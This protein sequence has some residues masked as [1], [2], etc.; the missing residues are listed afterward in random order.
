MEE[1]MRIGII[2]SSHGIKGSMKII[3]TTDDI[4]RFSKLKKAY[5]I[6]RYGREDLT[7]EEV[8]YL[9]LAVVVRFSQINTPEDAAIYR[10]KD[11]LIDRSDAMPLQE[12]RYYISDMIGCTVISDEDIKLGIVDDVFNTAGANAVIDIK[13]KDGKSVLIPYT[14]ECVLDV[15]IINKIIKVHMLDGLL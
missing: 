3:P 13:M 5:V 11:L 8:K 9:N 4:K 15:D 10:G 12:G 7:V 2:G 14:D 6:G 1:Y